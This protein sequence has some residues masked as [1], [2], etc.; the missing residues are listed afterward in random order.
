MAELSPTEEIRQL[1][2][3]LEQAQKKL[4]AKDEMSRKGV[5]LKVSPKGAIS[6][7]GLGKYPITYY[8]NQWLGLLGIGDEIKEFIFENRDKI[9]TRD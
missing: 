3:E 6:V 5:F 8:A 7:F 1:R 2:A 9:A 4:K